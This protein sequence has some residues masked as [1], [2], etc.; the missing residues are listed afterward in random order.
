MRHSRCVGPMVS[1]ALLVLL[2]SVVVSAQG[3][4]TVAPP[5]V[6][7]Q[8][9][10]NPCDRQ[11]LSTVFR[12]IA[13]DLR[14]IVRGP[15]LVWLGTGAVL[16]GGSILLDDEVLKTMRD[17]NPDL[18]L[19]AGKRLGHAGLQFGAPMALYVASRAMHHPGAAAFAVTLL[20]T[21]SVNGIL[22]RG[23]KLVPRP[24]P[25]Q[26][27]ATLT[28]GSFP[29]GHTS[30]MFATATVIQRKWGWRGG[31]PAYLLASYVG[32]TRL[33]NVHYL[34]DV[35]FGAALGIAAGLVVKVPHGLL[36]VSPIVAPDRAGVAIGINLSS[37]VAH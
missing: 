13:H 23:L 30:A 3:G 6:P 18:S 8:D 9:A 24:R 17:E 22:T 21:Q 5:A 16:S 1:I 37:P 25:Y 27:I 32:V 31:L 26:K 29:S 4:S 11:G 7:S 14:G 12:C 28:K 34:S 2:S 19:A 35:T 15:S 20:R 33:Q 10:G 36:A